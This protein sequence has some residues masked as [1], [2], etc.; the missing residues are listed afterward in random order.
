MSFISSEYNN[1]ATPTTVHQNGMV[2]ATGLGP[3]HTGNQQNI[4]GGL[5]NHA[6]KLTMSRTAEQAGHAKAAG[7]SMRGGA[8]S[9]PKV[10]EGGTIPGVSFGANHKALIDNLNQLNADKTY[11]HLA[12]GQPY[13]VGGRKRRR[14]TKKH[15]RRK[16]RNSMGNARKLTRRVRRINRIRK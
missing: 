7:V 9:I 16:S 2:V 12:G 10:P 13:K 8:L 14:K 4:E 15:G 11:D 5:S 6:V 1:M 3:Q